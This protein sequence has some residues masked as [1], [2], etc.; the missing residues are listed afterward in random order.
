MYTEY[1]YSGDQF[2]QY[3]IRNERYYKTAQIFLR[4]CNVHFVLLKMVCNV[5]RKIHKFY[6]CQVKP[7]DILYF[8]ML[9][10]INVS[11]KRR[12]QRTRSSIP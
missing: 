1:P 9:R 6:Q 12:N 10:R 7:E 8:A 3:L 2:Y 4:I 11:K 5:Q